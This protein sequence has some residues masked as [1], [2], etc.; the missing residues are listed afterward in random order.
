METAKLEMPT[1]KAAEL[2]RDYLAHRHYS[3]PIDDEIRR[4]LREIARGGVVIRALESIRL[5]GVN[6]RRL[7]KLAITRAINDACLYHWHYDGRARFAAT[8]QQLSAS[9]FA[10]D[11]AFEFPAGSFPEPV[12]RHWEND[13]RAFAPAI[14]H[15]LKPKRGLENYHILWEAEWEPIAPRDPLLLRR[16]GAGDMWLVVAAWDLTEIEQ[17]ALSARING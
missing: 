9:R 3:K 15:E 7:P 10:R 14:P 2:Y 1:D 16:L 11:M 13:W 6:E 5:A 4:V 17:L 12:R 8:E